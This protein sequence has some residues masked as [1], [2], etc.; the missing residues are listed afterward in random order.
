MQMVGP[1]MTTTRYNIKNK[2]SQSKK[3]ESAKSEHDLWLKKMGVGKSKLPVD[4][5]GNRV[6]IYDIPDYSTGPR[7]TSDKVAAN[8]PA[9]KVTMYTGNELLGIG[10][11]HKSNAVPIRKDSPEAAKDLAAMRR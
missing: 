1:Y 7:V 3:L 8:G 2:K 11:M 4:K 10:T 5:K 9:R 6:G